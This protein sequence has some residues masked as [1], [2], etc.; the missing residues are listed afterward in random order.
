L[1]GFF[2]PRRTYENSDEQ[3]AVREKLAGRL[4]NSKTHS[5]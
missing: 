5:K 3:E 4:N 2:W 1:K